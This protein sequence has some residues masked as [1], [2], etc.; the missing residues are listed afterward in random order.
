[1]KSI[2]SYGKGACRLPQQLADSGATIHKAW[3]CRAALAAKPMPVCGSKGIETARRANNFAA[4]DDQ[5]ARS[6]PGG[7]ICVSFPI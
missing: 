7:A 2:W 1:M 3:L 5:K 4:I 6:Q